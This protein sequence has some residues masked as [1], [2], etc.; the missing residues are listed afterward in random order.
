MG[1]DEDIAGFGAAAQRHEE[2][3]RAGDSIAANQAYREIDRHWRS[4]HLSDTDWQSAFL[5]LLEH[6]SVSVRAM[7]AAY[8]IHFEP[9]RAISVLTAI[10]GEPGILGFSAQMALKLWEKGELLPPWQV[11]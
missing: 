6:E 10:S 3:T 9:A 8:A 7:A 1:I 2:A 11:H 4:I 5:K